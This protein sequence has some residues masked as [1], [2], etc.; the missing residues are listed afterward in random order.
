MLALFYLRK[1]RFA[2]ESKSQGKCL[3]S[4]QLCLA[5]SYEGFKLC[6]EEA[7]S[8]TEVFLDSIGIFFLME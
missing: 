2:H 3:I 1:W 5:N 7:W 4:L 6:S 8:S